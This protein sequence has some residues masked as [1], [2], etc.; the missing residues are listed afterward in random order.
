MLLTHAL[1]TSFSEAAPSC[2]LITNRE[3]IVDAKFEM[4]ILHYLGRM[5]KLYTELCFS[6]RIWGLEKFI[7]E[8]LRYDRLYICELIIQIPRFLSPKLKR[9][10]NSLTHTICIIMGGG[11]WCLVY[12]IVISV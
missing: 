1:T 10:E 4:L 6:G 12:A 5:G 11:R 8:C 9:M 2:A 3:E 7:R